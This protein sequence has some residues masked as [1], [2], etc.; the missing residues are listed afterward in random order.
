MQGQTATYVLSVAPGAG[1]A[2]TVALACTG[3]PAKSTCT[4]SPSSVVLSGAAQPA[5]VSITT[6]VAAALL[7]PAGRDR[8]PGIY[9]QTGTA[10]LALTAMGLL[11]ALL[12]RHLGLG[13]RW[14]PV[15]LAVLRC[16]AA[17]LTSCG[18]GTS[19]G[20]GTTGTQAG[21]YNIMI[22]GTSTSGTMTLTHQTNLTLVVQ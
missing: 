11:M 6:T 20:G 14:A 21:T 2:Q 7:R 1:F 18:G 3:A 17:V 12:L 10:V 16:A 15:T 4:V 13:R 19:G 22:S 5:T 8:M 9:H